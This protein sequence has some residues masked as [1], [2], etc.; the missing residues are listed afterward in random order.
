MYFDSSLRVEA[1]RLLTAK[2]FGWGYSDS[3][4]CIVSSIQLGPY[5]I[6]VAVELRQTAIFALF[7]GR[8]V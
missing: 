6:N 1:L 5:M 2:V 7:A 8:E 3:M 4:D